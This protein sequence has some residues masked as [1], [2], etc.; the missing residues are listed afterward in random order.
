MA[1]SQEIINESE[2][3]KSYIT[4]SDF[5]DG[6]KKSLLNLVNLTTLS[7][8]GISAEEKIQKMTEAIHL[9]AITQVSFITKVDEKIE[10][11]IDKANIR[12]CSGCK[13]MKFA[14]KQEE[15]QRKRQ[16]IEEYKAA[17]G[18]KDRNQ[19]KTS[20]QFVPKTWQETIKSVL[21]KP[22]VWIW[23]MILVISP[24]SCD[25]VKLIIQAF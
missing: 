5:D 9:L 3:A 17:N 20:E 16:I 19:Q 12:Q 15:E 24:Y 8:N 14:N 10:K 23:G 2:L 25:L 13:A 18:I 11:S 22:Y 21:L 6:Y 1:L 7:T 4:N